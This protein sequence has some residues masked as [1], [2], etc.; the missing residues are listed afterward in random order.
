MQKHLI[1]YIHSLLFADHLPNDSKAWKKNGKKTYSFLFHKKIGNKY[2]WTST[3]VKQPSPLKRMAIKVQSCWYRTPTPLH[4]S[5]PTIP[6]TC[7]RCQTD[8]GTLLHIWWS[9]P[10]IQVFWKEVQ[11][12]TSQ[13]T[14]YNLELTPAQFLL[15]HSS[16]PNKIYH[17]SLAMHM[18]NAAK[19]CIPLHWNSLKTP[20]IKEWLSRINKIVEME[21]L[22][23]I[24]RDIPNKFGTKWECQTRFQSTT[25]CYHLCNTYSSI[26]TLT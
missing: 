23:H 13:V 25:K 22:I 3:K 15:H 21:E 20:S 4:K 26:R 16:L 9:Y 19:Q 1:S 17:N 6:D 14:S 11:R 18:I 10:L 7:W 24:T 12:I 5:K 8:R 2:S